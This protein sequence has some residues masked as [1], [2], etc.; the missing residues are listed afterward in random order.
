MI[1][2]IQGMNRNHRNYDMLAWPMLRYD[3]TLTCHDRQ[4][5]VYVGSEQKPLSDKVDRND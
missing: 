1:A 2:C 4:F 5:E 3:V